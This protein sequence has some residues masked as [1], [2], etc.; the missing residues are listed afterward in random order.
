MKKLSRVGGAPQ[1]AAE[2]IPPLPLITPRTNTHAYQRAALSL[3]PPAGVAD[4]IGVYGECAN[5][6]QQRDVQPFNRTAAFR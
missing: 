6:R 2:P 3:F 4:H 5:V 1:Q